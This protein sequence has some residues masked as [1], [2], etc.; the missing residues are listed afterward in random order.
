[1]KLRPL[2]SFMMA[3][4]MVLGLFCVGP[5]P[6]SGEEDLGTANVVTEWGPYRYKLFCYPTKTTSFFMM[7][8]SYV[9]FDTVNG[10]YW[11]IESL[12]YEYEMHT[13]PADGFYNVIPYGRPRALRPEKISVTFYTPDMKQLGHYDQV[14]TDHIYSVPR[15]GNDYERIICRMECDAEWNWDVKMRMWDAIDP[16]M[17]EPTAQPIYR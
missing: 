14:R 5:S 7:P 1:M 17:S 2:V 10:K 15:D 9:T 8:H 3:S 12:R 11:I 6:V 4:A 16:V 13:A